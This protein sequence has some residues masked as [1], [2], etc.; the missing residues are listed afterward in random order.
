MVREA[1][2]HV[3]EQRR[4][5]CTHAAIHVG[6]HRTASA[7][8]AVDDD[9][10]LAIEP[11]KRLD[12]VVLIGPKHFAP[13]D[14]AAAAPKPPGLDGEGAE[15]LPQAAREGSV[16]IPVGDAADVVLAEDGR[17]QLRIST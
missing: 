15:R 8:A 9:V 10:D 6:C 3:G 5:A 12:D 1:A 17:I 11:P 4:D 2:I 7:V 16:E 13:L 14:R